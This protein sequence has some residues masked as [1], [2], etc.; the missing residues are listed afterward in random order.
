M[1]ARGVW[2]AHWPA[3]PAASA[4]RGQV[5]C[6]RRGTAAAAHS[7]CLTARTPPP[8]LL[9][10]PLAF[11]PSQGPVQGSLAPGLLPLATRA[12]GHR[13]QYLLPLPRLPGR[14]HHP[15]LH[16]A[17]LAHAAGGAA[18]W[19][20]GW[21]EVLLALAGSGAAAAALRA[22]LSPRPSL[23]ASPPCLPATL[24]PSPASATNLQS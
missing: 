21:V 18:G 7:L 16:P 2:P 1:P 23:H 9:A 14:R 24:L 11:P 20:A 19:L 17:H 13:R 3:S 6:Q 4:C 15:P 5:Y 12:G 10:L 8:P 22:P